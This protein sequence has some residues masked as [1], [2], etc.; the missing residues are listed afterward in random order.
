MNDEL[1]PQE[2]HARDIYIAELISVY[3]SDIE[4]VQKQKAEY[5]TY[6]L[7]KL[8]TMLGFPKYK[9]V[10]LRKLPYNEI[11]KVSYDDFVNL[12]SEADVPTKAQQEDLI[13]QT[14]LDPKLIEKLY[15]QRRNNC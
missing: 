4:K 7:D 5:S 6:H 1:V 14:G 13:R 8:R 11:L 12:L 3:I 2:G 9:N 10:Q 15:L